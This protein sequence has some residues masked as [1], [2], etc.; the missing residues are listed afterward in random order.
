MNFVTIFPNYYSN[1]IIHTPL[2]YSQP[3]IKVPPILANT[4]PLI[5]VISQ[6]LK[7]SIISYEKAFSTTNYT[8]VN[9]IKEEKACKIA[10]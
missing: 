9:A 10:K 6:A 2:I 4:I 8:S 1:Q 5:T 7:S 3:T